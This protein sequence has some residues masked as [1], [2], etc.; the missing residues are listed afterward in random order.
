MDNILLR[1]LLSCC[2]KICSVLCFLKLA[3]QRNIM[4]A[5]NGENYKHLHQQGFC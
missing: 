3:D 4:A 2:D 1:Y 5:T